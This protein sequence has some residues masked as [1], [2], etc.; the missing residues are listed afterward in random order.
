MNGSLGVGGTGETFLEALSMLSSQGVRRRRASW[1]I[2][3]YVRP[4]LARGEG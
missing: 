2:V 1:A 3:R 4:A